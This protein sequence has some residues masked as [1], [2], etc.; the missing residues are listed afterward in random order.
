M[1]DVPVIDR[2]AL[3]Q[4]M[5]RAHIP[6]AFAKKALYYPVLVGH[7]YCDREYHISRKNLDMFLLI[8]TR[9]GVL[10]VEAE[11]REWS[12]QP[13]ELILIDCMKPHAYFAGADRVEFQWIHFLGGS[14]RQYY[15]HIHDQKS[16]LLH[17]PHPSKETLL[18]FGK[19]VRMIHQPFLNE[20]TA[21]LLIQR[22]L[23]S[24]AQQDDRR[25]EAISPLISQVIADL[26]EH[27]SEAISINEVAE[28]IKVNVHH[29]I[30]R[31]K[32]ETGLTPHEFLTQL[33][34]RK[35]VELLIDLNHSIEDISFECG[36]NSAS[37]FSRSFKKFMGVS[38]G[39]F[40]KDQT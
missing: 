17:L 11:G 5:I 1:R 24:F 10:S 21:S 9:A 40:R 23:R 28:R 30:R 13:G 18:D 14:S 39:R 29:L 20:Q 35:A 36:Y 34:I 22:L 16:S 32:L 26:Q 4:S 33:R 31:F 19:L 3:D 8:Y 7:Y 6:T 12:V 25:A 2:G 37:H 15:D 38:P 27:V